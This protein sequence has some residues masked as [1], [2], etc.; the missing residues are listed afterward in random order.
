MV[1]CAGLAD[2]SA[3]ID[4]LMN[5][6]IFLA[7]VLTFLLPTLSKGNSATCSSDIGAADKAAMNARQADHDG[8]RKCGPN[9]S[10]SLRPNAPEAAPIAAPAT[11]IRNSHPISIPQT[12]PDIAPAAVGC[13]SWLSL[14]LPLGCLTAMTASPSSIGGSAFGASELPRGRCGVAFRAVERSRR[15]QLCPAQSSV[16]TTAPTVSS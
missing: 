8:P 9:S 14:T 11:G 2:E 15:W 3:A 10:G 7:Y 5:G 4:A 16:R 13:K 1:A 6:E 12:A